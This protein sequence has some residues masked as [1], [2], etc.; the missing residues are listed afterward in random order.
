MVRPALLQALLDD[1]EDTLTLDSLSKSR[2]R[3]EAKSLEHGSGIPLS[4]LAHTLAFSEAALLLRVLGTPVNAG[5]DL[6]ANKN[7][8][9][10]WIGEERLPD[11]W[12]RPT[13]PITL[14]E[15]DVDSN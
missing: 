14:G 10:T 1:D 4:V 8:M 12:V 7:D 15:N 6:A 11:G 2:A 13:I 9:R 3:R 5:S